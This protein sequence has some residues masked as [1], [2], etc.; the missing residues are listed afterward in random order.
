MCRK[1]YSIFDLSYD[2]FPIIKSFQRPGYR[3]YR[4]TIFRRVLIFEGKLLMK[5]RYWIVG[6]IK[7]YIHFELKHYVFHYDF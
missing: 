6:M 7:H 5:Y 2:I 1:L 4:K 3:A